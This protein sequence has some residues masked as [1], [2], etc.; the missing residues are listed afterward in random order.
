[1]YNGDVRVADLSHSEFVIAA[2]EL[3][4]SNPVSGWK[5]PPR[6]CSASTLVR[7]VVQNAGY[8]LFSFTRASPVAN[9][10]SALV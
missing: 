2:V 7:R 6:A 4:L 1:A 3:P 5:R 8:N 10:Q 9:C